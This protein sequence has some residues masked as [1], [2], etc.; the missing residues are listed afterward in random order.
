MGR[1][2][3][4]IRIHNTYMLTSAWRLVGMTLEDIA[5]DLGGVDSRV[6]ERLE[7]DVQFRTRYLE[8]YDLAGKL[9]DAGQNKFALLATTARKSR[10]FLGFSCS[11]PTYFSRT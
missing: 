11:R 3:I 2:L 5:D 1:S 10:R 6:R 8:L 9:A 7:K 4:K